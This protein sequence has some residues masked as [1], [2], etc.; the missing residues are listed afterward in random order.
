[1]KAFLQKKTF[2]IYRY[3][4]LWV[5]L[6]Y[7][8]FAYLYHFTLFF[9]RYLDEE[10]MPYLRLFSPYI[11]MTQAGLQYI[12]NFSFSIPIWYLIFRRFRNWTLS[13]RIFLHLA[14][15]PCWIIACQQCYYFFAELLDYGHLTGPGS[16]WD[17]YIPSLFYVLQ[18]GIVHAYEYYH[19]NQKNLLQKAALSEAVLK[20]E[21]SALKAQLNPHF[22]YNVFNTIN[23]S[24]PPEQEKTRV[25]VA[26]LSDLFRYQLKATKVELVPLEDELTFVEKY[27]DLEMER[28]EDR[29]NVVIEVPADVRKE[30]VPPMILQP[31]VE[32]S[33]KHGLS[34]LIEGGEIFIRIERDG[35]K[36]RFEVTDTG[37]GVKDKSKVFGIG[38]GLTNTKLRLEKMYNSKMIISDNKPQ[39]LKI[40]FTI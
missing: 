34:S 21:L 23:A 6:F 29:L 13:K 22:L 15:L 32:N 33:I 31:L 10:T 26:K 2:G 9:N 38:V 1:M 39:G 37:V 24:V 36:I 19:T 16:V 11:F 30:M 20:S 12:V 17:I 3:E 27:L 7:F 40:Q 35:E 28:F 18:F 25:M 5:L 14:L 8:F 4:I